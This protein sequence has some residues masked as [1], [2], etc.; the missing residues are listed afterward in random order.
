MSHRRLIVVTLLAAASIVALVLAF[1]LRVW[2]PQNRIVLRNSS[3]ADILDL[4]LSMRSQG[5]TQQIAEVVP[6]LKEG[7][8]VVFRHPMNDLHVELE[9]KE[10]TGTYRHV[11]RSID[12]WTGEGWLIDILPDGAVREGYEGGQLK[13][14]SASQLLQQFKQ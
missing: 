9:F 14:S 5:G 6:R 4:Q 12:L 7:E 13:K 8:S 11:N 10:P 1:M 3:S 2:Y